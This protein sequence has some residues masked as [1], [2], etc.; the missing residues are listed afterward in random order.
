MEAKDYEA[1]KKKLCKELEEIK[2]RKNLGMAEIEIIDKLTHSI[3]SIGAIMQMDEGEYSYGDMSSRGSYR[4]SYDGRSYGDD[5]SGNYSE[6]SY[7]SRSYDGDR[8]YSNR[9][10]H[11]VRG[12]YSHAGDDTDMLMDRIQDMMD[13]S[14]LSLDDKSIL[15]K[16]MDVLRK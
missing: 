16:A 3:K 4:R 9:G 1:L 5:N 10:M 12:H 7:N 13:S 15:R 6:R 2:E 11:Y 14:G 8:S